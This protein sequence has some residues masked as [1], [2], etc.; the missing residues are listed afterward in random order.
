M[1]P[2]T[3][4]IKGSNECSTNDQ[5][6]QQS[7]TNTAPYLANQFLVY[8][9]ILFRAKGLLQERKQDR[10]DDAG[11]ETF[12]EANEENGNSKDVDTHDQK[13]FVSLKDNLILRS[14]GYDKD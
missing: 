9:R 13:L 7:T 4:S 12:S 8:D 1:M 14:D 6:D 5:T 2:L 3:K 11:L 10:D